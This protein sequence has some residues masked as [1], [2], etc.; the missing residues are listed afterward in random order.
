MLY[1][2]GLKLQSDEM[3]KLTLQLANAKKIVVWLF[4]VFFFFPCVNFYQFHE[5]SCLLE[6]SDCTKL[7]QGRAGDHWGESKKEGTNDKK[8]EEVER[9]KDRSF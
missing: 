4:V 9:V 6:R 5:L 8:E 1:S 7:A 2:A 3:A